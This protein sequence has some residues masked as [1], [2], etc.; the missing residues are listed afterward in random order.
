[1]TSTATPLLSRQKTTWSDNPTTL[2]LCSSP[3]QLRYG[4]DRILN[5]PMLPRRV[6]L[7][8]YRILPA[9]MNECDLSNGFVFGSASNKVYTRR[10]WNCHEL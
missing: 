2:F 10:T 5:D 9:T 3:R 8:D 6:R 1:M 4:L 7:R